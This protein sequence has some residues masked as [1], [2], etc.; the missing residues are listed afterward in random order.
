MI[1]SNILKDKLNELVAFAIDKLELQNEDINFV[2]NSLLDLFKLQAPGKQTNKYGDIQTDVIDPIVQYAIDNNMILPEENILFETKLMGLLIPF[3]SATNKRFY[4]ILKQD[5]AEAATNWLYEMGKNTNYLRMPDI[6]KNL[7]WEHNG[8]LGRIDITINLSKPEKDP[9]Q[10][11]LAKLQPKSGYPACM[12][13][14]E[15]V[16]Y[17]GHMNHPAR[18]TLRM[19]PITL[20][21]EPWNLQFG[22][23]HGD[24]HRELSDK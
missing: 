9:K 19:I 14:P 22:V 1:D 23:G 24:L 18:Q 6:K 7:K 10:I 2:R 5:G 4:E 21:S 17:A 8:K 11:A 12:L 16:G 20:N 13:C 15:N 3:P